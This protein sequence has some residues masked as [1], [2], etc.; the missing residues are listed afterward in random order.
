MKDISVKLLL[1]HFGENEEDHKTEVYEE[2]IIMM[3][4]DSIRDMKEQIHEYIKSLNDEEE[5]VIELISIVDYSEIEDFNDEPIREI[6]SR[7][8]NEFEVEAGI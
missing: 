8:L 2:Q 6:Y 4:S 7:F 1:K 3:R 5:D